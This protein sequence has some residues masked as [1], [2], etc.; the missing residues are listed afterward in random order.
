[1]TF[2]EQCIAERKRLRAVFYP[3]QRRTIA[4][5]VLPPPVVESLI[6]PPRLPLTISHIVEMPEGPLLRKPNVK[7]IISAVCFRTG[8]SQTDLLSQRRTT[9]I[10][11]PRQVAIYL[12]KY[13]TLLS[14]P[15]IGQRFGGRDHTTCLHAVRKITSLID[16]YSPVSDLVAAVRH[17]LETAIMTQSS[18]DPL[19]IELPTPPSVNA[20]YI[21]VA[22]RGRIRSP[23]YRSWVEEAGWA[24]KAQRPGFIMGPVKIKISVE[25][26]SRRDLANYEKAVTDLLVSHQVIQDDKNEIVREISMAWAKTVK[27][28][29][30]V[31]FP[32]SEV[33]IDSVKSGANS[34]SIA[35]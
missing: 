24:I 34:E 29:L 15:Q 26:N 16:C 9:N 27:G 35:E 4:R 6:G 5:K 8:I 31:V 2:A 13:Y 30:V 32:F 22:G 14:L 25:E 18:T 28:V 3:T 33:V 20:L 19:I 7:D 21:N 10:V 1:M 23:A 17:D 11:L 12:A